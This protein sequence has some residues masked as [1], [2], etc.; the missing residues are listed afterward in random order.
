[1]TRRQVFERIK[2]L[3]TVKCA[4]HRADDHLQTWPLH[5]D[6]KRH[7]IVAEF[8]KARYR[9]PC[10]RVESASFRSQSHHGVRGKD[11]LMW[12]ACKSHSLL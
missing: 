11:S 8:E 12:Y 4:R 6:L 5:L 9:M 10:P 7:E 1:M 3:E 2:S